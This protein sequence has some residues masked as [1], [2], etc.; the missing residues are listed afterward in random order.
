SP[1]VHEFWTHVPNANELLTEIA[2]INGKI[3]LSIHQN[4]CEDAIVR[5]FLH[6]LDENGIP[7]QA[8]GPLTSDIAHF[9]EPVTVANHDDTCRQAGE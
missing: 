1:Y 6:Q 2:A 3:F 4:F 9:P 8:N 7:Y 5:S